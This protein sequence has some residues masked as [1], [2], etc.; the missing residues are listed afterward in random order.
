MT[1]KLIES[2]H[3]KEICQ[4]REES[5]LDRNFAMGSHPVIQKA[6]EPGNP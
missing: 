3:S 2:K 5:Y 6:R 4:A 1:K